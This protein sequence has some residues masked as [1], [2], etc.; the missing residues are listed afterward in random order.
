VSELL[1]ALVLSVPLCIA[2]V[3]TFLAHGRVRWVAS[4][5]I[6]LATGLVLLVVASPGDDLDGEWDKSTKLAFGL[7]LAAIGLLLWT[8]GIACGWA[9]AQEVRKARRKRHAE[10][11]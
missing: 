7:G 10:L 5:G 2:A 4:V 9:A 11:N 1:G 3:A 6:A 8:A